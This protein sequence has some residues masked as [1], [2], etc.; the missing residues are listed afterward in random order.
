MSA[1][2]SAVTAGGSAEQQFEGG[3]GQRILDCGGE[4]C[5]RVVRGRQAF[6]DRRLRGL[7]ANGRSCDDCHMATDHF[8][9]SPASVEARFQLLKRQRRRNPNADDPLFRPID[10]D[11]F[12]TRGR[13][14]KDF[15][16][17]RQNALVRI[18]MPLP[19]TMR[20]DRSGDRP[21]VERDVRGR[22]AHGADG[23]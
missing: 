5:D 17:L 16:H 19:P 8:Q 20:L 13:D 9:L 1:S 22:V 3:A 21:A 11:D 15:S 4:P 18:E 6:F 7:D 10:A 2:N 14:A 23:E 12:R